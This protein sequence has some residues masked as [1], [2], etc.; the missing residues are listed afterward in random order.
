MSLYDV[1]YKIGFPLCSDFS[2][3]SNYKEFDFVSQEW[4]DC[5]EIK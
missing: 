2:N 3:L 5:L 1:R 4:P